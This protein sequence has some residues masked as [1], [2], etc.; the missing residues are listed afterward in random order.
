M[1]VNAT[2][3]LRVF[4]AERTGLRPSE[5][6]CELGLA[7]TEARDL[8]AAM[9]QAGLLE[10]EA[11]GTRYRPAPM[12]HDLAAAHRGAS[13]L[14]SAAIDA[15]SETSLDT[16]HT[17][18]VTM[19]DGADATAVFALPGT[20]PDHLAVTVSRLSARNAASG[21]TLL[22]RLPDAEVRRL[23][24]M[25]DHAAMQALIARLE[26]LRDEGYEVSRNRLNPGTESVAVA[27]SAP[28]ER[29]TVG[30]CIKYPADRLG[31]AARHA[32][33]TGLLDR[34][35]GMARRMGDNGFDIVPPAPVAG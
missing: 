29:L 32:I 8:L 20:A 9:H 27:V 17:G 13:P 18:F 26:V 21:R 5:A 23:Y 2:R 3:V 22:A 24:P 28:A 35:A 7:E 15:V 31:V 30:M 10:C 33:I 6:A 12:A 19:L 25:L 1:L 11:S 14:I 34:A 16:G 4:N